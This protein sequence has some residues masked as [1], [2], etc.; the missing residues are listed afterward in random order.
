MVHGGA[1]MESW[2]S[3]REAFVQRQCKQR[4]FSRNSFLFT[5]FIGPILVFSFFWGWI[6]DNQSILKFTR[7]SQSFK[8]FNS[9]KRW[10][11]KKN[12]MEIELRC[13]WHRLAPYNF[14]CCWPQQYFVLV[15]F[16]NIL[17]NFL[18]DW[19]RLRRYNTKVST[20]ALFYIA[21]RCSCKL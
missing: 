18:L 21:V 16:G 19:I 14:N 11:L 6:D 4:S 17:F 1:H 3:P 7:L 2:R 20:L 12:N 15:S 5:F 8:I 9:M 10:K 13:M